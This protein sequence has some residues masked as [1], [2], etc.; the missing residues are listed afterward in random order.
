MALSVLAGVPALRHQTL[1][2]AASEAYP[3]RQVR[4]LVGFSAGGAADVAARIMARWLSERLGKSFVVENKTGGGSNIAAEEL[5]RAEPDGHTLLCCATS[6]AINASL[7]Q[8]LKFNFIRDTRPVAGI[9]SLPNVLLVSPQFPARTVREFI[10]YTKANPGQVSFASAGV[11][12]S[13]HLAGE[14]FKIKTGLDMVHVPFRGGAPAATAV[15][16]G[17]VQA[18]FGAL[19]TALS[20][21]PSGLKALGITSKNRAPS[22]PDVP[23]I[24]ETLP[25]YD[26]STWFGLSMPRATPKPIVDRVSN[27]VREGLSDESIG[28]RLVDLGGVTMPMDPDEFGA[29]IE[30]DTKRWAEVVRTTGLTIQ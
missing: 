21:I 17:E 7:Y 13:Q 9:V 4:L 15:L 29:F 10:D 2:A 22:L 23:P 6:N 12:S 28:K 8:N 14:L 16:S 5:V 26:V 27:T 30:A 25:G 24:E 19:T 18:Y 11:G 3:T 20:G 1:H